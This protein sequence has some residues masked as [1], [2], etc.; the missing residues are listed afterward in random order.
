MN[1]DNFERVLILF[2]SFN[3]PERNRKNL[4][5]KPKRPHK[6][7]YHCSGRLTL[8]LTA[9]PERS[10]RDQ[11]NKSPTYFV[12]DGGPITPEPAVSWWYSALLVS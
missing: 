10:F 8:S 5:H 3:T 12:P 9:G 1:N 7:H 4:T 6:P 11:S 2:E